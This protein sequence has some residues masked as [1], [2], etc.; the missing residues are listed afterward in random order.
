MEL[1][2]WPE[3]GRWALAGLVM[4]IATASSGAP[5]AE[6]QSRLSINDEIVTSEPGRSARALKVVPGRLIVKYRDQA[7]W[8]R[9]GSLRREER[10]VPV[11]TF[12]LIRAEAV[13]VEGR[14]V[15]E[16]IRSLERRPDVEYAEPDYVVR[17]SGYRDEPYFD[18]LWGLNNRGQSDVGGVAGTS[19][20]D[21]NGPEA[22]AVTLGKSSVVVAVIDDG[23][24][25]THPDL[26]GRQWVNP[27]EAGAMANNGRDDDGNGYVDDVNGWDFYNND[28]TTHDAI[29]MDAHGTHVAGTIAASING[30]GVVGVAPGVKILALKF[31]GP[32]GGATSDAISAIQYAANKGVRISNNSWGGPGYSQSLKDAIDQSGQLFVTA[33][34]NASINQDSS[35]Y[36]DYPAAYSS[37]NIVAVA[38]VDNRGNLASFSNYGAK[39]VDIAAPGVNILSSV[40][41]GWSYYSGTSMAAPHVAGVAALVRSVNAGLSPSGM[42]D[43]ILRSGKPAA[44]TTGKTMTG[45]LVDARAALSFA[46]TTAPIGYAPV[47]RLSAGTLGAPGI[48]VI[49]SWPAATDSGTSVARYQ[50]QQSSGSGYFNVPLS[51]ALAR[52]RSRML[53]PGSTAY[54]F[55]VR[56][57]DRVGRVGLW[58]TGPTFTV[59]ALQE[60]SGSIAYSG[61]WKNQT[62]SG[63]YGGAVNYA[64]AAGARARLTFTGRNVAWISAKGS[65]YGKA[66]VYLDG[67]RVATIDLYSATARPRQVVFS[68]AVSPS[69]SHTLEVWVAGASG[70][71]RVDV[72]AL[73]TL[74]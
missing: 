32:D 60:T 10:L 61:I 16:A 49:I 25:F 28:Q 71:S 4:M 46:D 40:P 36:P 62:M 9:R 12:G 15:Q 13:R 33:A 5:R 21:L 41:D 31:L 2:Y 39:T 47:Q 64:T 27:G 3:R 30:Q 51:S 54:T 38:A 74:R 65:A 59:S 66:D 50:L 55:R 23:V 52:S 29:D 22:A 6:A 63:A 24:D 7:G 73:T 57:Y 11:R 67:V 8:E 26:A 70:R 72:D 68:R 42:K 18:E 45:K 58:K 48:P 43:V 14:S 37:P 44:L 35:D 69:I 17:A 1:S 34:G 53:A 20:V 19:N 56:A